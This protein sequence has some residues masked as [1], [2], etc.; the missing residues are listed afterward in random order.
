MMKCNKLFLAA[1]AGAVFLVSCSNDNDDS[2]NAPLGRYDNGFLVLNQGNFGSANSNVSYISN[3]FLIQ[4]N[5]IF[6]SANPATAMGDT[7]QDIGFYQNLAFIVLNG[8]NKIQIVNRYTFQSVAVIS[9]GLSNPRYIA[10]ANGRGYVT[11]WGSGSN[12]ADDFVAVVDLNS[13]AV[14]STIPVAE[15]PEKIIENDGRLYVAH[16]GGF[17]FGAT[18]SVISAASNT[19]TSTIPVGDVPN[20][21]EIE[22][23]VLYVLCGG[24]PSWTGSQTAGSLKQINLGSSETASYAFPAGSHP[25][26]MVIEDGKIYYTVNSNIYSKALNAALPAAP[27]FSA[28]EAQ[29]IYSFA[30]RNNKVFV[31]DALDYNSNG[32]VYIY[33]LAGTLQNQYTAGIIPAGF[34]FND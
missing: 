6:S 8:S 34:Y 15:G 17:G 23:G 30:V 18:V 20:A 33:S 7:G 31:G 25:S 19:V 1:L 4:E 2:Q 24:I 29:G 12:P 22:N 26:N 16:A 3:D 21:L 13:Y 11:N 10:F 9:Q 14:A 32:K 5:N 28:S 27:L